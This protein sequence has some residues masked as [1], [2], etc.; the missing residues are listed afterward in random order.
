MDKTSACRSFRRIGIGLVAL[1]LLIA[2]CGG[3]DDDAEL[4]DGPAADDGTATGADDSGGE[5]Q[6]PE[7]SDENPDAP[8]AGADDGTA[9]GGDVGGDAEF[10][11]AVTIDEPAEWAGEYTLDQLDPGLSSYI[12]FVDEQS[13]FSLSYAGGL[14]PLP[15]SAI[16]VSIDDPFTGPGTYAA[17]G[18]VG[19]QDFLIYSYAEGEV[20][21]ESAGD[22]G[23]S[24]VFQLLPDDGQPDL[25]ALSGSWS[26]AT[27]VT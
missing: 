16:S 10:T 14:P 27:R 21:V 26:C 8:Q 9:T 7:P 22:A 2:G 18:T 5:A 12:C 13:G 23:S 19:T 25:A 11:M 15:L 6:A 17:F 24:G 20:T 4:D 3:D 1:T